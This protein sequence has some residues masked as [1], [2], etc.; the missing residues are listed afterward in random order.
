MRSQVSTNHVLQE[1][2]RR[3]TKQV[4]NCDRSSKR[5]YPGMQLLFNGLSSRTRCQRA[6]RLYQIRPRL[7]R[8]LHSNFILSFQRQSSSLFPSLNSVLWFA[9]LAQP[10]VKNTPCI[11]NIAKCV[12]RFVGN[13]L[14]SVEQSSQLHEA[15]TVGRWL[16]LDCCS[17]LEKR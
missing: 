2:D 14:R 12:R 13:A 16:A 17:I 9:T 10:S 15:T 5:L 6:C 7:R 1:N 3:S 8:Y 11:W 4:S